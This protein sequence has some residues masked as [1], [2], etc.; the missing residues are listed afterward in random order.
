MV[1]LIHPYCSEN[2]IKKKK[3]KIHVLN[4]EGFIL[5]FFPESIKWIEGRT[6]R[7]QQRKIKL[8]QSVGFVAFPKEKKKHEKREEATELVSFIQT[9]LIFQENLS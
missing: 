3:K 1:L 9:N 4:G 7:R 5:V 8:E 6:R 2:L